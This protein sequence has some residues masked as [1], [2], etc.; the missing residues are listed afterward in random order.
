MES[1]EHWDSNQEESSVGQWKSSDQRGTWVIWVSKSE[2]TVGPRSEGQ[3]GE[4]VHSTQLYLAR[5]KHLT[6]IA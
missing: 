5:A 4:A 2:A 3:K 6:G 1:L